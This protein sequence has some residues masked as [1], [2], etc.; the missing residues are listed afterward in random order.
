MSIGK[1]AKSRFF[2]VAIVL[3]GCSENPD[4]SLV[5]GVAE[6]PYW[7]KTASMATKITHFEGKCEALGYR[8]G[9]SEF[10]GCL[11]RSISESQGRAD[12]KMSGG[13]SY[14]DDYMARSLRVSESYRARLENNMGNRSL[15]CRSYMVGQILQTIC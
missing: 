14:Y 6:S 11:E 5:V 3:M 10:S 7:H 8:N 9:T 13:T 4:G 12:I 1:T 2:A 15:R